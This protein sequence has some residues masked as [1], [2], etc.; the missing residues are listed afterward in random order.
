MIE[1][2][3]RVLLVVGVF[4]AG[5]AVTTSAAAGTP[6][7][8]NSATYD[9][10]TQVLTLS[11]K[12]LTEPNGT[13]SLAFNDAPLTVTTATATR[14]TAPLPNA[15]PPGSYLVVLHR[16]AEQ[17][18]EDVAVFDV[19]IGAVGA[20][21]A[22]GLEGPAGFQGLQGLAGLQGGVGTQGPAG[23]VGPQGNA[24]A[25]GASGAQGSA[26]PSGAQGPT[27][28]A[29]ALGAA[30]PTGPKGDT[31]AQGL[32]GASVTVAD[33]P[34]AGPCG[35]L[36]GLK[37]TDGANNVSIVCDGKPGATGA[38]GPAGPAGSVLAWST[39]GDNVS[40]GA[41]PPVVLIQKTVGGS[42]GY[43][44]SASLSISN[45]QW[46]SCNLIATSNGSTVAID[47]KMTRPSTTFTLGP[48]QLQGIFQALETDAVTFQV[49]CYDSGVNASAR[50][51]SLI[52]TG[53]VLQ[54]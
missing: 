50:S 27:G 30:G 46:T 37:V 45:A 15:M 39:T 32:A 52:V 44:A 17:D 21:G 13:L 33:V 14:I 43:V 22:P 3:R 35:P 23:A 8:I 18:D 48:M 42:S 9:A 36:A 20:R 26:G 34:A 16:S 49:A 24:G 19:T 53:V 5:S 12:D 47:Q 28:N 51:L 6:P 54:P 4:A 40:I 25:T 11:G 1:N 10:V 29:G 38:A 2:V 41:F 31:G 7:I